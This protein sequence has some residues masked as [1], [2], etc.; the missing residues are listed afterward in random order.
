MGM[1]RSLAWSF[2]VA[3]VTVG[4]AGS[5]H[6][7]D[8]VTGPEFKPGP[9]P[10]GCDFGGLAGLIRNYYPGPRQNA[11]IAIADQMA[12]VGE[13]TKD[14]RTFGF[15]IMDSIGFLSRDKTVSVDPAAGAA[16]TLGLVKCMFSGASSFTYPTTPLADFT[17]AL[18]KSDGGAYYVRGGGTGVVDPAG[19]T[20]PP[21][22]VDFADPADPIPPT[23]LSALRPSPRP[24]PATGFFSWT[25][26]LAVDSTP[27]LASEYRA[28]VY[29][30][31]VGTRSDPLEYEWA[32]VPSGVYFNPG[33]TVTVCDNSGSSKT[34]M[35]LES[36]IGALAFVT[37]TLCDA[38][39]SMTMRDVPSTLGGRLAKVF[40][41]AVSPTP[42]QAATLLTKTGTGGTATTFKSKFKTGSVEAVT[43]NFVTKPSVIYQSKLPVTITVQA[44]AV[45]VNTTTGKSET[46]GVNGVC[47]YL[48]GKNNNGANTALNGAPECDNTAPDGAS[49]ITKTKNLAAG[50]ATFSLNIS[51]TG[52]L[53]ITA[54]SVDDTGITG[55]V[56]RDDQTF[57]GDAFRTNIKP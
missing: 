27:N 56:G 26:A 10:V 13:G 14:A 21:L 24:P 9:P 29:G 45:V 55:V 3:L 12:G 17:K 30:Y 15:Q 20:E 49:A 18:N 1:S 43:L 5:D 19:R 4:C 35:V 46:V 6:D 37:P 48:A 41:D 36:G 53:I 50:Y 52:A 2:L 57:T 7:D 33:V 32:T 22:G 25:E 44:T 11:I 54:S 8:A 47:V 16:L 28:L 42:L 39:Q 51:K 38:S 31:R 40:F 23:V 34:A